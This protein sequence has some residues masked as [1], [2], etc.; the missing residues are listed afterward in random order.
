MASLSDSELAEPQQRRDLADS[1]SRGRSRPASAPCRGEVHVLDLEMLTKE[2]V[3][4]FK[5]GRDREAMETAVAFSEM[6]RQQLGRTH[7]TYINALATVA[8]LADQMG[9]PDEAQELLK[10]AEGLHEEYQMET[11]ERKL[12]LEL[13]DL[14]SE[15]DDPGN[16]RG[17]S[18]GEL[19]IEASSCD[20]GQDADDDGFVGEGSDEEEA[21]AEVE[22][23]ARLTWEVN[24]LIKQGEPQMAAQ[25]LKDAEEVLADQAQLD[26]YDE[27]GN[28]GRLRGMTKAALHA[29]WAAVLESVGEKDKAAI[30]YG[31]ALSCLKDD[32]DEIGLGDIMVTSSEEEDGDVNEGDTEDEIS[33]DGASA[34]DRIRIAEEAKQ[35]EAAAAVQAAAEAE[36]ERAR[37]AAAA[38]AARKA[39]E[40]KAQEAAA[41]AEAAREA[42]EA[43]A[44]K[45]AAALEAARK[46]QEE[47][48]REAAAAEAKIKADE[49]K[50]RESA[51]AANAAK[52]GKGDKAL[53]DAAEHAVG[54]NLPD[55]QGPGIDPKP[56]APPP[57]PHAK[58]KRPVPI[59]PQSQAKQTAASKAP[60]PVR[61]GGGFAIPIPK[62]PPPGRKPPSARKA[63]AKAVAKSGSE[64]E[65]SPETSAAASPE[66]EPLGELAKAP[67]DIANTSEQEKAEVLSAMSTADQFV[68]LQMF[69][70]A[71]DLLEEKLKHLAEETS[72]HYKSDLFIDVLSK[73]GSILW[74]DLDLE[75]AIDAYNAADE[76][77]AD[78]PNAEADASVQRRRSQLWG[79]LAQI[80]R[81]CGHL[82]TADQKLS[83]AIDCL[84]KVL[85]SEKSQCV[86]R[87]TPQNTETTDLLRDAQA[88]LGQVCVQKKE[89]QRA[90]TY[91][92]AAFAAD[93]DSTDGQ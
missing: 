64:P 93:E 58:Q 18:D 74:W 47:K 55:H 1:V 86:G 51:A 25:L 6:A 38:E 56:K 73:Y 44:R 3:R 36:E 41:A 91:Y 52:K 17:D 62:A 92:L 35:R 16:H 7:P 77:L 69:D 21:E 82:D 45:T 31:E 32:V 27:E 60:G 75:G 59:A 54:E 88:A 22:A 48:E 71:A 39:E 24:E 28:S 13:A 23:L 37:E 89:Y 42:E 90:E 26:A 67:E 66:P 87:D 4:M 43:E 61:V 34:S 84:S 80:H 57:P 10:E 79:K 11:L 83:A 46:A 8:A 78:R 81:V 63:K 50:A 2:C 68:G 14:S 33:N 85:E 49:E 76:V 72:P 70:R 53:N 5:L 19:E 12:D 15:D 9:C 65:C 29:L 40:E 20:S 30:L